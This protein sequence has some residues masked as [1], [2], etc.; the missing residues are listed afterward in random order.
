VEQAQERGD[1]LLLADLL[2]YELL[3]IIEIWSSEAP[4]LLLKIQRE[5]GVA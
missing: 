4:A 1:H 2:E 3:P 5:G